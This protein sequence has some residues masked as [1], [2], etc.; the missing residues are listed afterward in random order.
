[1]ATITEWRCEPCEL[2][3]EVM[4][5]PLM[6]DVMHLSPNIDDPTPEQKRDA[7]QY[8]VCRECGLFDRRKRCPKCRRP[9]EPL[10]YREDALVCPGCDQPMEVAW[11][12]LAD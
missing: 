2:E 8:R 12:M 7:R 4:Y 5:G 6:S 11:E 1:M 10:E 9:T 3:V